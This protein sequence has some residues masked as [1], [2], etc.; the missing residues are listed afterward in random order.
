MSDGIAVANVAATVWIAEVTDKGNAL[1]AK[2]AAGNTLEIIE[3]VSG[4]GAV[5]T[6]TLAQ[7]TTV[8]TPQQTVA[9][10]PVAYPGEKMCKLPITIRNDGLKTSY[11]CTNIGVFAND[12]DEGKIL[13]FKAAAEGPGTSIVSETLQPGYSADFDFYVSYGNADGVSVTVDPSNSVT[14]G[15]M[16]NYVAT[17]LGKLTPDSEKHVAYAQRAGTA[18]KTQAALT[19]RVNGGRTEGS[20]AWTFDGSTGRTINITPDKIG[21]APAV[22]STEYPGCYYRTVDGETE[23]INPPMEKETEY[24][25]TERWMGKPVYTKTIFHQAAVDAPQSRYAEIGGATRL[26]V[27][28]MWY[29]DDNVLMYEADRDGSTV[30]YS[31]DSDASLSITIT[32]AK[33]GRTVYTVIKYTK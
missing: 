4:S 17:E 22:E 1:L 19:I 18:D 5:D 21:A 11:T 9:I 28:S 3:A 24:R 30:S 7:Q 10:Q 27:D 14:Q 12:P 2:L 16:E 25:T 6:T 26:W 13:F 20:N 31:L 23:W 33:A 8:D 29:T 15:A 32:A